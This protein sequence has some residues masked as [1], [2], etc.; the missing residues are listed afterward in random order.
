MPSMSKIM[1]EANNEELGVEYTNNKYNKTL[2]DF[3]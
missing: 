3:N 2:Y 1:S